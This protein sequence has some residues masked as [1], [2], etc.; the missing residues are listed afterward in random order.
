MTFS[1][2]W[3]DIYARGEQI[4]RWPWSDLVSAVRRHC[5]DL[6]GK[7]V[8]ELGCG[9]GGNSR[10]FDEELASY[11]GMDAAKIDN[12]LIERRVLECDFTLAVPGQW[13]LIFDRAAVTHNDTE[14]IK[15]CLDLVFN[16]LKPGGHYIGIDWF[17][18]SHAAAHHG[19][20]VDAFTRR[21]I[22]FGQ[23]VNV[24]LVHFSS[25]AHLMELFHR[26]EVLSLSEKIVSEKV[27]ERE[28]FASWNIVARRP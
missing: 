4:T 3:N 13:D 19:I 8:L 24:G 15:R 1:P 10:F 6:E 12:T 2:A 27:L 26:F 28:R 7:A 22:P 16:A 23:F 9:A 18:W 14:S 11:Y 20:P 17:S 25:M 21:D 5:G